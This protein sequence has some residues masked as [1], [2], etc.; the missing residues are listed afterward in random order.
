MGATLRV[1]IK[2]GSF[3]DDIIVDEEG[4]WTIKIKEKPIDGAANNYL[5]SF[6]SKEF[7]VSKSEIII[8]KGLSSPFKKI[9]LNLGQEALERMLTKYKK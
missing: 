4:N 2:P 9:H 1:K 3:K 5:I 6:L 8:E 7:N